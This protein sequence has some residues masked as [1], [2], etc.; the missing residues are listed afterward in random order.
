MT[1]VVGCGAPPVF[2]GCLCNG[3]FAR[4]LC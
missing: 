3:V 1:I 4:R 2:P